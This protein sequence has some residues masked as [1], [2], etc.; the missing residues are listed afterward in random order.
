MGTG[1]V[2]FILAMIANTYIPMVHDYS[3]YLVAI[4][5][6]GLTLTLFLIG[7]RLLSIMAIISNTNVAKAARA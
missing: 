7:M 6:A 1:W 4:A 5:K 2:L 3:S